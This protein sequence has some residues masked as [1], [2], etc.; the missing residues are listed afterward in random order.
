MIQHWFAR[1]IT[2]D[3]GPLAGRVPGLGLLAG[4]A[5]CL[6]ASA[7]AAQT[8]V[9]TGKILETGS[10][11]PIPS[12]QVV[13][14]GTTTGTLTK[15]DG[16]F[17]LTAPDRPLTLVIRRIGY[18][19]TERAVAATEHDVQVSLARDVLKLDEI[20]VTGQST[21]ISR[22]NLSTS[23][24]TVS[25]DE[26]TQVPSPSIENALQGKIA[27]AQIQSNTGAPGGGNRIR[28]RGITSLISAAQPLYVIDGVIASDAAIG[29]GTNAIT[30]ASG[31]VISSTSQESP[32]NRIAD[33]NPEDI[34]N[35]EVLK[36]A[37][38]SAIY[39]SK[40]SS[41]VIL[42]TTKK[43]GSGA[44]RFTVRQGL[45]TQ[46]LSYKEGSRHFLTIQD[47]YA[48]FAPSAS[49]PL[50]DSVNKYYDPNR[51]ID[52][53]DVVYGNK[54]LNS[55]T[56]LTVNGGTENTK[57][58]MS[59]LIKKDGGI[60]QNTYAN[61]YSFRL[62]LDQNFSSRLR[63]SF[64]TE[65]LRTV[66]DR[67]LFG[68]DNAGNTIGYTLTKTPSWMDLRQRSDGSFPYNPF[69]KSNPLQTVALVKNEEGVWRNISSGRVTFDAWST[70]RNTLQLI[71]VGGA[72]V[73]NQKNSA[74][75]PPALQYEP[76]DGY[77]GAYVLS[78]A[79]SVNT[80]VN[81]NAVHTF[82]PKSG[83]FSAT[84]SIGSQ[85]ET[86]YLDISRSSSENLLSGQPNLRDGTFRNIDEQQE[87]V[88]DFGLFAQEE[89]LVKERLLLTLGGRAD[90]SSNNGD[91]SK[92]FLY[93]KAS[94]SYRFPKLIPGKLEELKFR[95]AYGESGNQ[96]AYGQKFS[97]LASGNVEGIGGFTYNGITAAKDIR[98][99]RQH[100]LEGGF[101]AT[102][103]NNRA[104]AELTLFQKS[105]TDLLLDRS[106]GPS[107]G[108]S[109]ERFNGAA[110]RVRGLEAVLG[111]VPVARASFQWNARVN[112]A[113]NRAIITKLPVP[114]FFPSTAQ[115]GT[116]YIQ[117]GKSPTQLYGNDTVSVAGK[118]PDGR[119]STGL[120]VGQTV[121]TYMG[122]ANPDYTLGLSND[123]KYKRLSLYVLFDHLQ[124]GLLAA[125]TYRHYDLGANSR[126]YDVIAADGEKLG[127]QRARAYTR[128]TSIYYQ[129]T[130]YTKL[131]E[132]TV[133]LD[134]PNRWTNN[135]W[136]RAHDARLSFSGRNLYTWTKFRGGD[137]DASNF[138]GISDNLQRN[139]ELGA[140]PPS[141]SFWLNLS[142]GF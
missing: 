131:R 119:D 60:V 30:K 47:A 20:V 133:G 84:T 35:I 19:A 120:A 106:L 33:L 41:G 62:N 85:Y 134:I 51:Q 108:F 25:A 109:T 96:P 111:V 34:E 39:G 105:I 8:R 15:D 65:V 40:A 91:P 57:Y 136:G 121:A 107:S 77:P 48:A 58:Y 38:A 130:T 18:P 54:P 10:N 53:E 23:I 103:F 13:V 69:Y 76:L 7:A 98:P 26:L 44:P 5:L 29:T 93:P 97:L 102:L 125:G 132:L 52:Y 28:L 115:V 72:D 80:N 68:N 124:G 137:P 73:F 101:D 95:V 139:R 117:Q 118:T 88:A 75:S 55:E 71:G 43:G 92:F 74:F 61:K 140:Y 6:G 129:P 70:E 81:L 21:G 90:R 116:P 24:A 100:E 2:S 83:T 87:K 122:D 82:T 3:R 45:G 99:E 31:G 42:I 59:G 66:S 123:F 17:V 127:A 11:A 89:L 110:M 27:G 135:L 12:A 78:F 126:D 14:K 37:A 141:R 9:I 113:L 49:S 104:T 138:G 64:N 16:S 142:V 46:Q 32:V 1:Y 36:G 50:R 67:G 22:R 114:A 56:A 86:R 112:F 94:G 79:N 128:V 4:L 63:G